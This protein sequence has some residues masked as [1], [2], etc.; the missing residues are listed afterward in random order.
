MRATKKILVVC[1][2][3]ICR[4]PTAD[5]VLRKKVADAGLTE[6]LVIDSAGTHGYHAGHAPD[7]RSQAE[8]QK[9]GYDLSDIESRRVTEEDFYAFDLILAM[10]QDNLAHLRDM[11]P[12]D[13]RATLRLFLDYH[14]SR[15]GEEVPDPYY[16]GRAGFAHVLD[17]IEVAADGLL[18]EL[19]D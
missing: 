5:G 7:Q 15:R 11:E 4:S 13:G 1:M 6:A 3:N 16:G 19:S 12:D 17:L 14:P 18:A 9:N 10:D 2:G 8:A